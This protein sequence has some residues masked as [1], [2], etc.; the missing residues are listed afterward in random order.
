[1]Q[2]RHKDEVARM[3]QEHTREKK[4]FEESIQK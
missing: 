4:R 3:K 1:L 2:Q